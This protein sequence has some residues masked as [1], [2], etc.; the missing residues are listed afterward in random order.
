MRIDE[1]LRAEDGRIL[2]TLIRLLGDFDVAEE[3]LPE[4]FAAALEQRRLGRNAEAAQIVSPCSEPGAQ[5]SP[6]DAIWRSGY[7]RSC[8]R[9][10]SA[11]EGSRERAAAAGEASNK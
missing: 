9:Q 7:A 3:A 1:I 10:R 2:A 8:G 5:R 6:S 11:L 4:A